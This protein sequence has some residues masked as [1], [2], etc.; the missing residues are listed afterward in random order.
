MA[1]TIF[2][3]ALVESQNDATTFGDV[4][5]AMACADCFPGPYCLYI[6]VMAGELEVQVKY[7]AVSRFLHLTEVER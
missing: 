7:W 1:K 4:E 3:A 6:A 2:K 5:S